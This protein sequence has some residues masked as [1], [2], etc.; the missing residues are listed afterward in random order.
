MLTDIDIF[1]VEV[2]TRAA[3]SQFARKHKKTILPSS[4]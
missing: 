3:V 4:M 1:Q 2:V